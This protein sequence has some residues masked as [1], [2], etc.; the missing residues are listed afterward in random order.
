MPIDYS[1]FDHD[2]WDDDDDGI[3]LG[4][5]EAQG[6]EGGRRGH[7]RASKAQAEG[8]TSTPQG[9]GLRKAE[10]FLTAR[11]SQRGSRAPA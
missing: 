4:R 3:E 7:R 5:F 6:E 10:Q 2:R 1:R 9:D 11:R 8:V